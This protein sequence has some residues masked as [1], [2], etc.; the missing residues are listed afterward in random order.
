[1]QILKLSSGWMTLKYTDYEG[2]RGWEDLTYLTPYLEGN[3]VREMWLGECDDLGD[4]EETH[5][6]EE[7]RIERSKTTEN[8]LEEIDLALPEE[9][10]RPIYIR[11]SFTG[12]R[13]KEL[14]YLL[15]EYEDVFAWN[16]K[17]MPLQANATTSKCQGLLPL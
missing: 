12:E 5:D 9:E 10:L 6:P 2:L 17:Q 7:E 11:K 4:G 3:I 14:I 13:K 16:Y 1:M 8:D 15:R